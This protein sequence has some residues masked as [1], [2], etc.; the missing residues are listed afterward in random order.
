MAATEKELKDAMETIMRGVN[1]FEAEKI[2]E[3][4]AEFVM[5]DH[6]TL[7]QY[8]CKAIQVFIDK[9]ADTKSFDARNDASIQWAIDVKKLKESHHLPTI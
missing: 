6:R 4:M 2:G 5:N 1:S 8:F 3:I 7:Q 9:Y